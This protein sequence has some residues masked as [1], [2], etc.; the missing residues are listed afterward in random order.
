[1]SRIAGSAPSRR[2]PFSSPCARQG[3]AKAAG[4]WEAI[5]AFGPVFPSFSAHTIFPALTQPDANAHFYFEFSRT[6]LV[7]SRFP[8]AAM[9]FPPPADRS[10]W[11]AFFRKIPKWVFVLLL[12]LLFGRFILI[13]LAHLFLG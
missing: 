4:E 2:G 8:E 9:P 6:K 13:G 3:S 1:M 11:K 12:V 5:D 7:L 10:D